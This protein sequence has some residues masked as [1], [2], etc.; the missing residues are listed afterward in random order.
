MRWPELMAALI[1]CLQSN[2]NALG[3]WLRESLHMG[4][5]ELL[6]LSLRG[7]WACEV[8][9]IRG[10]SYI[11]PHDFLS[12]SSW[13]STL[14]LSNLLITLSYNA[15]VDLCRWIWDRGRVDGTNSFI[16]EEAV[17]RKAMWF[18]QDFLFKWALYLST[19]PLVTQEHT[20]LAFF[21][22]PRSRERKL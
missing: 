10:V 11:T 12:G 3:L 21:L 22:L 17:L 6:P 2:R 4:G 7:S 5:C 16:N 15:E 8:K 18:T 20:R 14:E 9:G 13:G 19:A 1:S